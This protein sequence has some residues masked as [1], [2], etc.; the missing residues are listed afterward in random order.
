MTLDSYAALAR[1]RNARLR[2]DAFDADYGL[3]GRS[4]FERNAVHWLPSSTL[5]S[6]T[7]STTAS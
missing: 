1:P 2:S 3:D 6:P 4:N 7:F 5:P